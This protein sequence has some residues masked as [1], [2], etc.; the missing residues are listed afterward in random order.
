MEILDILLLATT[1]FAVLFYAGWTAL[2]KSWLA[3]PQRQTESDKIKIIDWI[4]IL[5][6]VG[7]WIWYLFARFGIL[8]YLMA[9]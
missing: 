3:D 4:L 7:I 8:A 9:G 2:K 6:F 5:F 1:I